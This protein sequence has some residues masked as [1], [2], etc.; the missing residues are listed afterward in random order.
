MYMCVAKHSHFGKRVAFAGIAGYTHCVTGGSL[1][2]AQKMF[3]ARRAYTPPPFGPGGFP[4]RFAV[5]RGVAAADRLRL[6]RGALGGL[7]KVRNFPAAAVKE[8]PQGLYSLELLRAS[9][10]PQLRPVVYQTPGLGQLTCIVYHTRWRLPTTNGL[11]L[12]MLLR[13]GFG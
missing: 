7:P 1:G 5:D 12:Q 9:T 6:C 10:F 4:W 11:F 2:P 8:K 13:P 3:A